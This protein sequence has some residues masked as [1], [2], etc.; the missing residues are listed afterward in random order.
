[1]LRNKRVRVHRFLLG[2][3]GD[4]LEQLVEDMKYHVSEEA[5]YMFDKLESV[6]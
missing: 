1:M 5:R 3:F 4:D 2:F 6:Y